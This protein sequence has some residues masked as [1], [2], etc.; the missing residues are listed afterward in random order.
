MTGLGV[1]GLKIAISERCR[2]AIASCGDSTLKTRPPR[3]AGPAKIYKLSKQ[4]VPHPPRES[5][6]IWNDMWVVMVAKGGRFVGNEPD[7]LME[8]SQAFCWKRNVLTDEDS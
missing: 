8:G 7:A 2:I 4:Q 1:F 6:G 3:R 5:G